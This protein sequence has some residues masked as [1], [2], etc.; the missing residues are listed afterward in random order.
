MGGLRGRQ[1]GPAASLSGAQPGCRQIPAATL[2]CHGSRERGHGFK[3]GA[4][5]RPEAKTSYVRKT[6]GPYRR[7]TSLTCSPRDP[8]VCPKETGAHGS[9]E[10]TDPMR[11]QPSAEGPGPEVSLRELCSLPCT[12]G[13]D[14][15]QLTRLLRS[16]C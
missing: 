3:R 16:T 6:R 9:Q 7:C 2:S 8:S 15:H 12:A 4:V 10:P 14:P 5:R 13:P 1:G 11:S